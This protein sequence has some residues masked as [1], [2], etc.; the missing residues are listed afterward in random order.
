M[1]APRLTCPWTSGWSPGHTG[2]GALPLSEEPRVP[3]LTG[4][5]SGWPLS[6]RGLQALPGG[7]A[8]GR[9]RGEAT[10]PSAPTQLPAVLS[11]SSD[12]CGLGTRCTGRSQTWQ[13][14][15]AG[16]QAPPGH[17]RARRAHSV[18]GLARGPHLP[19]PSPARAQERPRHC[20]RDKEAAGVARCLPP[21]GRSARGRSQ[22]GGRRLLPL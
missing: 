5:P 11:V 4:F 9:G 16:G 7:C 3:G 15:R 6:A 10:G 20:Q 19:L 21:R 18:H 8:Q 17:S 13:T 14:L 1:Q 22:S 12:S 2:R